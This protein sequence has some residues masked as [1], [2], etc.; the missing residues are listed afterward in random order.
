L[1]GIY[2]SPENSDSPAPKLLIFFVDEFTTNNLLLAILI[3]AFAYP[4]S[5]ILL[6]NMLTK[7][8]KI[9]QFL[10]F[11]FVNS[12]IVATFAILGFAVSIHSNVELALVSFSMIYWCIYFI[13]IVVST[14]AIPLYAKNIQRSHK[15]FYNA[16]NFVLLLFSLFFATFLELEAVLHPF[17][18]LIFL[19][20]YH[21]YIYEEKETLLP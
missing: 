21:H 2:I 8:L 20:V 1:I 5:K 7:K 17:L 19:G 18:C 10:N 3:S 16:Q 15:R 12:T 11:L 9:V 4:I 6:G 13:S 14:L